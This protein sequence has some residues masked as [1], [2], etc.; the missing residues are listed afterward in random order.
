MRGLKV[1][2]QSIDQGSVDRSCLLKQDVAVV[3]IDVRRAPQ[4]AG[5]QRQGR[6]AVV[7]H[8]RRQSG[9]AQP[10][11]ATKSARPSTNVMSIVWIKAMAEFPP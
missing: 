8:L 6:R 10:R 3:A 5:E 2:T 4:P 9:T 7:H 1:R 11:P